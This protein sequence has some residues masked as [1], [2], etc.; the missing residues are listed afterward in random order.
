MKHRIFEKNFLQLCLK[1]LDKNQ[2]LVYAYD[3]LQKLNE[4]AMPNPEQIFGRNIDHDTH[5]LFAIET[6]GMQ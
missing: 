3:E 4:E 6:K 5:W 1:I 2:R